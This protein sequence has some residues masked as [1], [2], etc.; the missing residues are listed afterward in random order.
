[1]RL[2]YNLLY[3]F[4]FIICSCSRPG[5]GLFSK[6]QTAHEKYADSIIKEGQNKTAAGNAWL[7]AARL[8]LAQPV[9]LQLPYTELAYFDSKKPEAA[10]F[11]FEVK[12]GTRIYTAPGLFVDLFESA[13][14]TPELLVSAAKTD[15]VL[16][17]IVK[18][19][20]RYIL[21]VQPQIGRAHV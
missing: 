13:A 11:E 5:S 7:N 15:S 19:D 8:S 20:S 3:I 9:Q 14:G 21:R 2:Q 6:K 1:M 4:L 12:R 18:N 17:Y 10:G 16:Q